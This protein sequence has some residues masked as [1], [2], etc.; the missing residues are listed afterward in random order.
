[1]RKKRLGFTLVELLVVIAIIGILIALLLPA[2]QAARAAARRTQCANNF[3]QAGLGL[4]N[5]LSARKY[6]PPGA[7]YERSTWPAVCGPRPVTA[8]GNKL[9]NFPGDYCWASLIL[10]YLEEQG[11]SSGFDYTKTPFDN[12]GT[13]GKT[14]YDIS[15]IP[16]K[17]YQCPDDPQAGELVDCCGAWTHGTHGDQDVQHTS[18]AAV[19]DTHDQLCTWP[20]PKVYAAQGAKGVPPGPDT[21]Y[22]N[23]AFG[24]INAARIKDFTDGLTKTLFVG[25]VL[26]KGADTY[27]GHYW[28]ARNMCDVAG[29]INGPDTVV[30]GAFPEDAAP[31]YGWRGT[32]FASRHSGGCHFMMGD[33]STRFI[34]ETISQ[35]TLEYLTTRAGGDTAQ[36][37]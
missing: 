21:V 3:K 9:G 5:Y 18:M 19:A 25:E 7:L 37:F 11:T 20:I 34:S 12:T 29:G 14:N 32:G 26:G 4:H 28:V 27:K 10:P 15:A 2:V 35:T 13:A 33:G 36:D 8:A 24:N 1:M 16:I 31:K 6:F 22:S 23:G 17:T 30:G